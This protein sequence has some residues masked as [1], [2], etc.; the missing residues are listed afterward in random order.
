M[1]NENLKLDLGKYIYASQKRRG[2]GHD[3]GDFNHFSETSVDAEGRVSGLLG[4]LEVPFLVNEEVLIREDRMKTYFRNKLTQLQFEKEKLGSKCEHYAKEVS[5]A[6]CGKEFKKP[7][8]QTFHQSKGCIFFQCFKFFCLNL[9]FFLFSLWHYFYSTLSF[10]VRVVTVTLRRA[11]GG[12][13]N[14]RAYYTGETQ[15][16]Q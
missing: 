1:E 15:H 2:D 13:T 6:W 16:Y 4:S 9:F 7:N 5:V 3:S 8:L 10:S 11:R 14:G 12:Q